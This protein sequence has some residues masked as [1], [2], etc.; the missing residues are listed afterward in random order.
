LANTNYYF[1]VGGNGSSLPVTLLNFQAANNNENVVL[2]WT[3]STEI[4]NSHFEVQRSTYNKNWNLIA[5]VNGSG[6]T[7]TPMR[8]SFTDQNPYS[9]LNV[10]ELFYRLKQVDFDEN[11][12]FSTSQNVNRNETELATEVSIY[13]NPTTNKIWVNIQN[14]KSSHYLIEVIDIYG[15]TIKRSLL[16]S[17]NTTVDL[18][19]IASGIYFIKVFENETQNLISTNKIFKN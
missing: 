19:D 4:N 1:G 15:N 9:I 6:N 10:N 8:Y 5:T 2:D 7:Q 16:N 12:S 3:T 17:S 13:P 14:Q 18:S 11:Y